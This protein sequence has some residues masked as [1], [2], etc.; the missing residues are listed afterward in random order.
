MAPKGSKSKVPKAPLAADKKKK[1]KKNP[2]FEKAPRNYRLGG[3]IQPKRDLT[4]FVKWPKYVR[5]QRAK[6]IMLM[7]LKVPPAIN[8][9]NMAID[10]N[11]AA[12]VLK[13]C[14]KYQPETKEAKKQ[15]LLDMAQQKKAGEEGKTKK[16]QVIKYGLNHV[17]TL[18]E[19][20]QAKLVVIAH[21]V[22]PIELVCWL[23][24]LCRKKDV[25]YCIIKGK[26]RLGQLVH[27][28]TASCVA[29]TTVRKE[30]Q[31]ELDTLAKNFHAQFNE[32]TEIRRRWGGGIMGIKSQHVTQR[33]EKA[34]AAE[35][36][37]K[38]GLLGMR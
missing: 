29:F 37:K 36:A 12:Q 10:K 33:R 16:P 17:T 26:S 11:Q 3:D 34:I 6:K 8:Q 25:P 1:T 22:D 20:K 35:Q 23:P 38:M 32:N 2:L 4:R 31:H 5:L 28:K 19:N 7:R 21:D 30:E 9:F 27:K 15:R 18:I 13:L 14:K 24:A